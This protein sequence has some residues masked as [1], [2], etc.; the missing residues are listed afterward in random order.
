MAEVLR[1]HP[2]FEQL[3]RATVSRWLKRP[4]PRTR[5]AVD[6]LSSRHCSSSLRIAETNT[7]SAIPLSMLHWKTEEGTPYGLLKKQYGLKVDVHPSRH[8][9]PALES[10]SNN[11]ADLALIPADMINQLPSHCSRLALLSKL[12]ICG[13]ATRPVES[14]FDLKGKTFGVLSGSAFATRLTSESRNWGL[15]ES[16]PFCSEPC[17]SATV[18]A[19]P[20][21]SLQSVACNE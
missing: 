21:T 11:L 15:L 1:A 5:M 14:I 6:I 3:N 7:L 18:S 9:G 4:S 19:T 20:S 2:G 16:H 13:L 12:Y 17:S 10:L 8:G